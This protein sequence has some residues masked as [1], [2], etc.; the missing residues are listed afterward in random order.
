MEVQ[1]DPPMWLINHSMLMWPLK[2]L[3]VHVW[4]KP[5][6]VLVVVMEPTM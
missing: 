1:T 3:Y 4:N 6:R 2:L 5:G